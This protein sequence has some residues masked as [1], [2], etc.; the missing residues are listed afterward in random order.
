MFIYINTYLHMYFFLQYDLYNF[1]L[2]SRLKMGY[3]VNTATDCLKLQQ[4]RQIYIPLY[5][6]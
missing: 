3:M 1:D 4:H 2:V 6:I 5:T